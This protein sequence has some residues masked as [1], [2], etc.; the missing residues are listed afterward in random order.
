MEIYLDLVLILNFFVDFLLILGTNRLSGF[1][2]EW[3]KSLL[4]AVLGS[5]YAGLCFLPGLS[6]LASLFWR[7]IFLMLMSVVAFGWG[8]N[9]LRRGVLFVFL[10]MALG[11][12]ALGIGNGGFWA[13]VLSA[14]GVCLM[15]LLGF[16]GKA[17][18][19]QYVPIEIVHGGKK[20]HLTALVDTGNTLRDPVSNEPVLVVDGEIG[21]RLLGLTQRQLCTPVETV[22]CGTIP[23]LRLVPYHAV[24]QPMGMLLAIWVEQLQV[25]GKQSQALVAFAPQRIGQG[26]NYEA[27]AGGLMG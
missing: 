27:L 22:A 18:G 8:K 19:S 14:I 2:P 13:L 7:L 16:A 23:G 5:V 4:A 12:I 15:C 21:Q 20:V 10:S 9:A 6:F 26:K 11:G 17:C 24:G 25:A 3:K 1:P